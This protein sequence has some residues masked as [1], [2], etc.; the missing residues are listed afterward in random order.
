MAEDYFAG[1]PDVQPS[2]AITARRCIVRVAIRA[3]LLLWT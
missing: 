2:K 1:A 3:L